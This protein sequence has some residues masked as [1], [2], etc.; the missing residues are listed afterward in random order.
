MGL[1]GRRGAI[2]GPARALVPLPPQRRPPLTIHHSYSL[3]ARKLN[4]EA[5]HPDV[6]QW[7]RLKEPRCA[8]YCGGTLVSWNW[9]CL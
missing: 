6:V 3:V 7:Y 4:L 9:L 5:F 2:G 8:R 1:P